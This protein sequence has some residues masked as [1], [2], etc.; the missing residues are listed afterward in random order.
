MGKGVRVGLY[1]TKISVRRCGGGGGGSVGSWFTGEDEL[2]VLLND[3][4]GEYEAVVV[5]HQAS[6]IYCVMLNDD[7]SNS[8]TVL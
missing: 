7:C 3:D 6:C 4:C 8:F 2:D 1:S 5:P